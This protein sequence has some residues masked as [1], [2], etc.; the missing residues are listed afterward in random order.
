MSKRS[1]TE[2]SEWS[3]SIIATSE[4]APDFTLETDE[5]KQVSLKDEG[6]IR[7]AYFCLKD[8]KPNCPTSLEF[9]YATE[10][11]AKEGAVIL[12]LFE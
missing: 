11:I 2:N 3:L 8:G 5:G 4:E 1:H 7:C 10:Q 9:K 6:K 12:G